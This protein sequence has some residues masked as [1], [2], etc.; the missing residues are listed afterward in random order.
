MSTLTDDILK[1]GKQ[2]ADGFSLI[3]SLKEPLSQSKRNS[4]KM[5]GMES[6][7]ELPSSFISSPVKFVT[8]NLS[9]RARG[10]LGKFWPLHSG[11]VIKTLAVM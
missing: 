3:S 10:T 7:Q 4:R 8:S 11:G 2:P 5:A 9:S 6:L 1:G